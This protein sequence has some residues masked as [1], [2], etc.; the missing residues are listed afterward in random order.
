M[1]RGWGCVV[2]LVAGLAAIS[3]GLAGADEP[4]T[5]DGFVSL[6]NGEDLTGWMGAVNGYVV[7]E[8]TMTCKPG[9]GGNLLTEKEYGDFHL[10]FE[11]KLAPGANNGLAIRTPKQGNPAYAGMEL[12][13]LDD[14]HPKY[15]GIKDWQSH[16]S[17]YGVV[18]AKRGAL[19]PA[20]E[21]NTEEVIAIGPRIKVIVN[22]ETIVDADIEA[23]SADGTLDGQ[24][25]PGLKREA[26]HIGFAG[27]G[28]QVTFRNIR[29][30]PITSE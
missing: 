24:N 11:F 15:A 5:D 20:G 8:G 1:F 21:W 14:A 4:T 19:K 17:I 28:D 10:K 9:H 23:A 18:A 25:H 30:K 13:I 3:A 29:I 2:L 16:G 22:G 7:E 12:Q 27:H 26:G 6:F